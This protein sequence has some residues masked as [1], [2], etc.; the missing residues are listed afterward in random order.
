[1]FSSSPKL[2]T[3]ARTEPRTSAARGAFRAT[4]SGIPKEV[5]TTLPPKP[6]P[7]PTPKTSS[8][9]TKSTAPVPPKSQ[10]ATVEDAE[11]EDDVQRSPQKK[12]KK[13][14]KKKKKAAS[15][16]SPPA[17]P[18]PSAPSMDSLASS[19]AKAS[20]SKSAPFYTPSTTSLGIG[21]TTT[22]QSS[23]SYLQS[24]NVKT[25]KKVK[26]RPDHA[27][28]FSNDQD[29]KRGLFS[30]ISSTATGKDKEE[31]MA[32]AKH[33]WF[34]KLSKKTTGYMHQLLKTG[35][36][37]GADSKGHMKW[38][39][40]LKIMREMGFS[41]DPSTAG[42]SVRFDP[43][44]RSDRPITFHKPHPDTSLNPVIRQRFAK[45]LKRVYGWCAE[46]LAKI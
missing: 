44:D 33:S 25:E 32:K 3:T 34:S 38:E 31:E 43:P 42:S 28:I 13:K 1:M 19:A 30:K 9:P 12:K 24:L 41:Y 46:D 45:R 16:D 4:Q 11:D 20:L 8:G 26:T 40:F 15:L 7:A 35:G 27:S 18:S 17:S 36:D 14:P 5:P 2:K 23:H 22:A 21:E 29:E 39:Q 37:D 10:K 6:A